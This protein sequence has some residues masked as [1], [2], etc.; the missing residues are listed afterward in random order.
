MQETRDKPPLLI[1]GAVFAGRLAGSWR[2]RQRA[3]E[4]DAFVQLWK[5]S[6]V[7]GCETAWA[8]RPQST[9]LR[10]SG[11]QRAA[12]TA[13]WTWAQTQPNRRQ[14]SSSGG[15]GHRGR[16]SADVPRLMRA[17]RGGA[18][19]LVVFAA[20]KWLFG[21]HPARGSQ[22]RADSSRDRPTKE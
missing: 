9:P 8:G 5:E 19:G 16:R 18:A 14:S 1:R 21:R 4:Q 22:P 11:P 3:R 13:G 2:Q 12:W 10:L 7:E 6:W 17:A 15:W 20:A